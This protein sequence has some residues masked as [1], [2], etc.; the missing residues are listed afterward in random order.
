MYKPC[1]TSDLPMN[2]FAGSQNMALFPHFRELP[3]KVYVYLLEIFWSSGPHPHLDSFLSD[4]L[5]L[6]KWISGKLFRCQCEGG[7]SS[8]SMV[9]IRRMSFLQDLLGF[10]VVA[11]T[12]CYWVAQ[13]PD[14]WGHRIRKRPCLPPLAFFKPCLI[15]LWHLNET[16]L[17]AQKLLWPLLGTCS[18]TLW[19]LCIRTFFFLISSLNFPFLGW[20]LF[21][22]HFLKLQVIPFPHWRLNF[23]PNG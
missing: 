13:P 16:I 2:W 4:L 19:L 14:L 20:R 22:S 15:F 10:T 8:V 3:V 5:C 7:D 9:F 17:P 23:I 18:N 1:P 21:V 6:S 12:A 11:N